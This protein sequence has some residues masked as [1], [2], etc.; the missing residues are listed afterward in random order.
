MNESEKKKCSARLRCADIMSVK[1][2]CPI[3]TFSRSIRIHEIVL[4]C[5]IELVLVQIQILFSIC[6]VANTEACNISRMQNGH[7]GG[8]LPG[9]PAG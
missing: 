5:S 3:C 7:T 2:Q 8:R 6:W 4:E 9:M 1:Y